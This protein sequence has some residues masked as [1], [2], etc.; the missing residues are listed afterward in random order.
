MRG[1]LRKNKTKKLEN[2]SSK[3][4]KI[5]KPTRSGRRSRGDDDD[6]DDDVRS[7]FGPPPQQ[8]NA[9]LVMIVVG[10]LATLVLLWVMLGGSGAPSIVEEH[11]A[12]KAFV[13]VDGVYAL[14]KGG[15]ALS[16]NRAAL[17][18]QFQRI[19]ETFPGTEAAEKAR[20]RVREL[21]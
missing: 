7:R 20:K 9:G 16:E 10:V 6:E 21:Q 4:K 2:A 18:E 1:T 3:A 17:R 13:R 5:A 11:E 8:S 14:A 12:D 15:D 19:A